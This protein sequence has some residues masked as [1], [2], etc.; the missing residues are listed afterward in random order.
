[1]ALPTNEAL[2]RW[3]GELSTQGITVTDLRQKKVRAQSGLFISTFHSLKGLSVDKVILLG[4]EEAEFPVATSGEERTRDLQLLHTAVTRAR[5]EVILLVNSML[6]SYL[7]TLPET[8]LQRVYTPSFV[9]E[10]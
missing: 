4:I 9:L 3:K 10:F 2:V 6:T 1:M 7:T 8:V 5:Q